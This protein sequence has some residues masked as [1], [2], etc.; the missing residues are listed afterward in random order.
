MP[1]I[2]GEREQPNYS[3]PALGTKPAFWAGKSAIQIYADVI[4]G[5]YTKVYTC[6]YMYMYYN[7][8]HAYIIVDSDTQHIYSVSYESGLPLFRLHES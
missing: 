6:M 5:L 4:E 3:T 7:L 2:F 1:S 8:V